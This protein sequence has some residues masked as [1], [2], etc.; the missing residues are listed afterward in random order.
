MLEMRRFVII[1][2]SSKE[3]KVEGRQ[4]A[5]YINVT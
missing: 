5:E 4:H 1:F 3:D 2:S